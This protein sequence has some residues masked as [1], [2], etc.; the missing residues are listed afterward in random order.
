[1]RL[2][3]EYQIEM[4]FEF[5]E[6][7]KTL[8]EKMAKKGEIF[9]D[10]HAH[11]MSVSHANLSDVMD[12]MKF[13]KLTKDENS[14][15]LKEGNFFKGLFGLF[16]LV[17]T[18]LSK[19]KKRLLAN[20]IDVIQGET[21][22]ILEVVLRDVSG[23]IQDPSF[24]TQKP[25]ANGKQYLDT[26]SFNFD[27]NGQTE[28]FQRFG[29]VPLCMDFTR[30]CFDF[31]DQ[32]TYNFVTPKIYIQQWQDMFEGVKYIKTHP[33]LRNYPVDIFPF[34]GINPGI[35]SNTM[36]ILER[37]FGNYNGGNGQKTYEDYRKCHDNLNDKTF[38]DINCNSSDESNFFAGIK[39]YPPLGFDPWPMDA[40]DITNQP[41]DYLE[42]PPEGPKGYYPKLNNQERFTNYQVYRKRIKDFYEFC[43]E[44]KIPIMVHCSQTG[45][46]QSIPSKTMT[47]FTNPG[48]WDQVLQ[49]YAL[50]IC[51]AHFGEGKGERK[52]KG[53]KLGEW[54][55]TIYKYIENRNG[56]YQA[57]VYTDISYNGVN[58]ECYPHY[59][60]IIVNYSK[61]KDRMLFGSDYLV[62]LPKIE[63]YNQYLRQ[64]ENANFSFKQQIAVEN[65]FDFLFG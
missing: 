16:N 18:L 26:N 23:N 14:E 65:P 47:K 11:A 46:W 10:A 63:S 3:I 40:S 2:W 54:Q 22:E 32:F 31:T 56:N 44:R 52:Y 21:G 8:E 43:A 41:L 28:S 1:M 61:F 7:E 12:R 17:G 19:K 33:E 24:N 59:E 60:K 35:H 30:S 4:F 15:K 27:L 53:E 57:T 64:F 45:G 9:F 29:F 20:F 34:L 37:F 51:F 25:S 5:V 58:P 50:K 48:R 42:N 39:L 36:E 62:N 55:E 49:D 38:E 13:L 6:V